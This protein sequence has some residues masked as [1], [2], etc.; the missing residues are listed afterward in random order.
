[1]ILGKVPRGLVFSIPCKP[2]PDRSDVDIRGNLS[3][4]GDTPVSFCLFDCKLGI[5]LITS[6]R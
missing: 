1:M 3:A 5:P 4:R 2:N 6:S